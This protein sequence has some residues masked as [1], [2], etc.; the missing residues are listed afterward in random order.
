MPILLRLIFVRVLHLY[1]MSSDALSKWWLSALADPHV[2]RALQALHG[3]PARRWTV[4]EL[5]HEAG[6]CRSA[7]AER[8]KSLLGEAPLEYLTEWRIRMVAAN[9]RTTRASIPQ[10]PNVP[11]TRPTAP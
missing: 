7:C 10:S 9:L 3:D 2:A 5:A 8:F 6:Q 11:D 1:P 4:A